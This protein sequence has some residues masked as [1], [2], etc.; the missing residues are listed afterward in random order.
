MKGSKLNVIGIYLLKV[1]LFK[2][3][4]K[5]L[6]VLLKKKGPNWL[7]KPRINSTKILLIKFLKTQGFK[8]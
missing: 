3:M 8:F 4:K 6:P 5:Y 1:I 7:D 2:L